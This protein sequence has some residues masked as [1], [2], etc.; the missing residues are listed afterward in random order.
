[1]AKCPTCGNEFGTYNGLSTHHWK[2]HPDEWEDMFWYNVDK[3]DTDE[4]WEWQ[5]VI[6]KRGYGQFSHDNRRY[7][8]HRLM[9]RIIHGVV[10]KPQVNHHCDN[11][12]CVNPNHL[13]SGTQSEN[14][15]DA[16]ERNDNLRKHIDGLEGVLFTPETA[17]D[18]NPTAFD[19]PGSKFTKDEVREIRR[20][21]EEGESNLSLSE[22]FEVSDSTICRIVNGNAYKTVE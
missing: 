20:R 4:C 11:P 15:Q 17:N 16:Y 13:Y 3:G 22:E 6:M 21:A 9:Y 12:Q 14:M 18:V 19:Q 8:T 10:P 7:Y 1:M 2:A 5:G